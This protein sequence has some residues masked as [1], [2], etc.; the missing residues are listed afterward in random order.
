MERRSQQRYPLS[1]LILITPVGKD[2]V[3]LGPPVVGCCKDLS[4][5]GI[6]FYH[7]HPL[8]FRKA[9]ITFDSRTQEDL[10]VLTVLGWCRFT[11]RGWYESGGRFVQAVPTPQCARDPQVLHPE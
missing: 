7:P 1:Q 6:G 4:V 2:D 11:R 8:P 3:I 5:R 9:I 10:S